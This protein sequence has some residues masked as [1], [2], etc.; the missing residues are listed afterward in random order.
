M[1]LVLLRDGDDVAVATR[2][3]PLGASVPVPG[4]AELTLRSEIPAGHKVA[5]RDLT[6]GELV[7]K[8]GQVIGQTTAPV[9]AGEH[10]HVHNLVM[11]TDAAG[12]VGGGGAG[13]LPERPADLR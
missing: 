9:A 8:Y 13:T 2:A 3:L 4:G 11:P 12:R 6:A 7:R 1:S 10:L 5:L